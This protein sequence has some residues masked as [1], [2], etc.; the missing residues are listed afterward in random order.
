VSF[1]IIVA[2]LIV[3]GSFT[4]PVKTSSAPA[5]SDPNAELAITV[6]GKLAVKDRAP[7][8]DYSRQQFGDG[9]ATTR[10]CDTRN[11][12][13]HRDLTNTEVDDTCQVTKGTLN[14]PYTGKV[15]EFIRGAETSSAVQIDRVV[16]I[17]DA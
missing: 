12:I 3:N 9:W 13:L 8:T 7:K 5:P 17:S 10:G 2:I 4:A 1:V 11:I 15:I 6:L 16:A 14:D